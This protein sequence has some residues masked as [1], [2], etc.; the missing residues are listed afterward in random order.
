MGHR[1]TLLLLWSS[2]HVVPVLHLRH[3]M[4]SPCLW[5]TLWY[6][7]TYDLTSLLQQGNKPKGPQRREVFRP[8]RKRVVLERPRIFR[9]LGEWSWWGSS[10]D[11]LHLLCGWWWTA[12]SSS[13]N[14]QDCRTEKEGIAAIFYHALQFVVFFTICVLLIL[15]VTYSSCHW[16]YLGCAAILRDGR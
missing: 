1:S 6:N 12:S 10:Y 3:G 2:C 9:L 13:G 11:Y 5:F 7:F 4:Q 8:T 14:V 16:Q 15:I